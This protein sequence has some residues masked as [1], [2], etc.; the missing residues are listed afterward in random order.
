MS[1]EVKA[2]FQGTIGIDSLGEW[3]RLTFSKDMGKTGWDLEDLRAV[4]NYTGMGERI[5]LVLRRLKNIRDQHQVNIVVT[6]HEGIDKI[7]AKGGMIAT[8]GSA[9]SEPIAVFGRPDIPGTS[10]SQEILRAFDNIFRVRR[11]GQKL[12]WVAAHEALGGGGNTWEVKDR[13]NALAIS[14]G[15]LPPSFTEIE[16]L[17]KANPLC[18]WNPPYMWLIYGPPGSQKTR[19]LITFPPPLVLH[20]IDRGGTVLKK[21][22]DAGLVTI[23]PYDPED[24]NEYDKFISQLF[25]TV[26]DASDVIKIR[27]ALGLAK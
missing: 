18:N 25:G 16:K 2:K 9:P 3:A 22:A 4:N 10:A 27:K 20:D 14:N 26:A 11:I 8:K 6:A 1:T 12:Q 21:E 23:Y 15:Y 24:H 19:S 13:F 7:Y 17:A 5:A